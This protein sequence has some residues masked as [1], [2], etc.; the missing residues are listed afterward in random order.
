[1]EARV[2]SAEIDSESGRGKLSDLDKIWPG[3]LNDR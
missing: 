3:R 2:R 1:V